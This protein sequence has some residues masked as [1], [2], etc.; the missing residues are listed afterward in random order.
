MAQGQGSAKRV[1]RNDTS[2][3][4]VPIFSSGISKIVES[5]VNTLSHLPIFCP[6]K[7]KETQQKS[8]AVEPVYVCTKA[9]FRFL[10]SLAYCQILRARFIHK[11]YYLPSGFWPPPLSFKTDS[12]APLLFSL[13]PDPLHRWYNIWMSSI[14]FP[15]PILMRHPVVKWAV[16][17]SAYARVERAVRCL[18][19]AIIS[20]GSALTRAR[21][22]IQ[23]FGP[24]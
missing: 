14:V 21:R 8:C 17:N 1:L 4:N 23:V 11:L 3:W 16:D 19:I 12:F 9:D 22:F 6:R 15:A 18:A 7:R 2:M 24:N 5:C 13:L 10:V 20:L